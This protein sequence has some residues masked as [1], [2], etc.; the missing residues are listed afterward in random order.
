MGENAIRR[1]LVYQST[2]PMPAKTIVA[3]ALVIIG[4]V[5]LAYSGLSFTT[6]GKPVEFLGLRMETTDSHFVPPWVGAISLL[7]GIAVF[8]VPS[9]GSS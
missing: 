1:K 4:I 5:I 6:P 9:K 7:A 8:F 2:H 3:L